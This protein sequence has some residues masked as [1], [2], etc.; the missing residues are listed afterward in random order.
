MKIWLNSQ[1]VR[2][3]FKFT[4]IVFDEFNLLL[5]EVNETNLVILMINEIAEEPFNLL[6]H[7]SLK[8]LS[9]ALRTWK[10]I[11]A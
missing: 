10:V 3:Q 2:V 6:F 5:F 8:F 7:Q 11:R 1:A 9:H 4:L